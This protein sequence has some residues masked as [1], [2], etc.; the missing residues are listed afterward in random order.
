MSSTTSSAAAAA[1]PTCAN[2]YAVP[3]LDA[4]CA[5]PFGGNH[6]DIMKACCKDA[7]VVSYYDDCGLYCLAQDQTVEDLRVCLYANGATYTQ[8]DVF[9]SGQDNATATAT[10]AAVPSTAGASIIATGS[11]SEATADSTSDSSSSSTET[12]GAAPRTRPEFGVTTVGLTVGAL[13]FSA[14]AF[15]AFQL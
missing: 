8:I 11:D 7:D 12:P 14:T 2:V 1:S 4:L 6:T 5:M 15:G 13:L 10:A 9:C 3:V